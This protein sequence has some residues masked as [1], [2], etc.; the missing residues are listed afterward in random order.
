MLLSKRFGP[1]RKALA[2]M[3]G[4][5][6]AVSE[7]A[8]GVMFGLLGA[9]T[10]RRGRSPVVVLGWLLSL[11]TYGLLFSLLPTEASRDAET[12]NTS[13]LQP[14]PALALTGSFVLGFSDS[15]FNTQVHKYL[16]I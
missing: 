14:D 16:L 1:N 9:V 3:N 11:A 13:L 5:I 8:G 4:I 2:S 6:I 10:T 7:V 12:D 15:C